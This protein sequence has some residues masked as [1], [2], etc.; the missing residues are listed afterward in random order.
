[1]L[2]LVSN[3]KSGQAD[4]YSDLTE[5]LGAFGAECVALISIGG[6]FCLDEFIPNSIFPV[7]DILTPLIKNSAKTQ[8][9]RPGLT[10]TKVAMETKIYGVANDIEWLIPGG[11]RLDNTHMSYVELVN[12]GVATSKNRR[13]LVAA[14]T[15]LIDRGAEVIVLSGTDLFLAFD[16]ISLSIDAIDCAEVHIKH[17]LELAAPESKL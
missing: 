16:D 7:V 9:K 4:I 3:N 17:L 11:K 14:C 5:R 15:E 6:S 10:G 2:N 12:A 1:M 13:D 8:H